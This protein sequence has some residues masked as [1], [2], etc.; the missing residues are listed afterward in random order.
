MKKAILSFSFLILLFIGYSNN[1]AP[2]QTPFS[3]QKPLYLTTNTILI[4]NQEYDLVK[5]TNYEYGYSE[6]HGVYIY[7]LFLETLVPDSNDDYV[8][9]SFH[10]YSESKKLEAGTYKSS[11]LT[12]G[13]E[14][15][16]FS[17]GSSISKGANSPNIFLSK[18]ELEITESVNNT[19]KVDYIGEKNG[20]VIKIHFEG[21]LENKNFSNL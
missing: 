10:I 3:D 18:G 15:N 4:D 21:E 7:T 5:G 2:I 19:F 16:K 1:T 6:E 20:S 14:A 17:Y 12:E 8:V 9:S 13:I 11:S